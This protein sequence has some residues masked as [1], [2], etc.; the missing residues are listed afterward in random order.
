MIQSEEQTVLTD[1]FLKKNF[2]Y[3]SHFRL[4]LQV[5]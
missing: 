5:I 2:R 4:A 3:C 1:V